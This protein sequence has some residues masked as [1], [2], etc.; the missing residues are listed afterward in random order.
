V[1]GRGRSGCARLNQ[2]APGSKDY[3]SLANMRDSQQ[4]GRFFDLKTHPDEEDD[5]KRVGVACR[6]KRG[7]EQQDG[8]R[9]EEGQ[10]PRRGD[11]HRHVVA[12]FLSEEG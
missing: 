6:G 8:R 7:E 9:L 5:D 10:D 11:E 12:L 3:I 2:T 4:S 1:R